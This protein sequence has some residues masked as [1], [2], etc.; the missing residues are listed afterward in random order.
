M[1]IIVKG[2]Y[3]GRSESFWPEIQ[4]AIGVLVGE[5]SGRLTRIY[6]PD[7]LCN[8]RT[9]GVYALTYSTNWSE[10]HITLTLE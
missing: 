8:Y 1:D 3:P 2:S 7:G 6:R 9:H 5:S 10:H 4:R